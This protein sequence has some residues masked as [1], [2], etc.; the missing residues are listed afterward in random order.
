MTVP[1]YTGSVAKSVE[2]ARKRAIEVEA[3]ADADG[4]KDGKVKVP[5]PAPGSF[6]TA[7]KVPVK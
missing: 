5:A 6:R 7:I 2:G 4:V 1:N 3:P